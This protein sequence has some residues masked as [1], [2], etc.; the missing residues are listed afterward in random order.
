MYLWTASLE[1]PYAELPGIRYPARPELTLMKVPTG[2]LGSGWL[3]IQD[4][5]VLWTPRTLTSC[6]SSVS[7]AQC[8]HDNFTHIDTPPSLDAL[9]G[10]RDQL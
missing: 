1:D 7:A 10:R 5:A 9:F 4:R 8:S 2:F 6:F 3:L